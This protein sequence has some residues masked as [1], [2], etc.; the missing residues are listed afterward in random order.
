MLKTFATGLLVIVTSGCVNSTGAVTA[1][2][3][4]LCQ[5]W[6]QSLPT[7]SLSDTEQTR[8]EITQ[9]YADFA[10]ACPTLVD[11]IPE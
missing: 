8:A 4:E 2:E 9:A 5:T 1:T 11:L 7:R 10:N 6:G 3:N